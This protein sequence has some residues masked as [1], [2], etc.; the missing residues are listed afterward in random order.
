M[1][2][3]P[4]FPRDDG[5]GKYRITIPEPFKFDKRDKTKD[6]STQ[7]RRLEEDLRYKELVVDYEISCQFKAK[8][9]PKSTMEPRYQ[10][11]MENNEQRR[12]EVLRQSQAMTRANEKP[13]SFY[14]W[15]VEN[16]EQKKNYIPDLEVMEDCGK[17]KANP[18]PWYCKAFL[19]KW[20]VENDAQERE[21]RI[22]DYAELSYRM[23]KLPPRMAQ[24]EEMKRQ[25]LIK[26]KTQDD[27]N[28]DF[29]FK[30]APARDVP[31]F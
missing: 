16:Y 3:F 8:D 5:K 27:F 23:S 18:V 6:K 7:Q 10:R 1:K 21:L 28:L 11:I 26:G 12:Q 20:M 13:F 19:F 29:T 15:D 17:F 24:Y 9:I 4:R 2:S 14:Q 30:P 31:D 25:G 22:K